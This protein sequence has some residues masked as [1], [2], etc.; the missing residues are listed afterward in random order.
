MPSEIEMA[1]KVS[2]EQ[3]LSLESGKEVGE[4]EKELG[5]DPVLLQKE[6][7]GYV[8]ETFARGPDTVFYGSVYF[9]T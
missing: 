7:F 9:P 8:F 1:A 5:E 4:V 2:A 3:S 6:R